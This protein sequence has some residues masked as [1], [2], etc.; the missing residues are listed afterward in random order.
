MRHLL[1]QATLDCRNQVLNLGETLEP[2]QFGDPVT[3]TTRY[4]AC[5]YGGTG[6]LRGEY[7]VARAGEI[8]GSL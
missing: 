6:E 3:G 8:C 4:A 1:S 5:L 7:T 2:S